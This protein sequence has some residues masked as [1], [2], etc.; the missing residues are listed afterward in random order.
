MKEEKKEKIKNV[1]FIKGFNKIT[2][3]KACEVEGVKN[4]NLYSLKTTPEKI[5]RIKK[6]IDSEINK[7]YE[8]YNERDSL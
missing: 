7:L 4:Q 6:Y 5:A 2:V 1:E 8:V 3:R